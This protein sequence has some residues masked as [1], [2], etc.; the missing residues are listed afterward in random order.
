MPHIHKALYATLDLRDCYIY[1]GLLAELDILY[2]DQT[3]DSNHPGHHALPRVY[4][5]QDSWTSQDEETAI[6]FS[7]WHPLRKSLF[8]ASEAKDDGRTSNM[9]RRV[10]ALGVTGRTVV[11]KARSRT[12]RDRWVLSIEAEIDRL[13]EEKR[14]DIR[15]VHS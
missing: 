1:S 8:R 15:V 5:S 3:F 10:S 14:E 2:S 4:P 11:F 13:Q 9:L 12:E 7:I 6:C